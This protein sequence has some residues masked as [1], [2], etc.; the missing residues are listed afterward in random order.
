MRNKPFEM[1]RFTFLLLHLFPDLYCIYIICI[2]VVTIVILKLFN[3]KGGI[4]VNRFGVFDSL[5]E[6]HSLRTVGIDLKLITL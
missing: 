2:N 1:Q 5:Y 6:A 4:D 3:T